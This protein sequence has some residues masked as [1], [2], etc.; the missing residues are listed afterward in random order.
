MQISVSE[1][2]L[3]KVDEFIQQ[4]TN[5]FLADCPMRDKALFYSALG[6]LFTR[7]EQLEE[8]LWNSDN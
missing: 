4:F 6:D 2:D 7:K 1:D 3:A 8:G 5:G